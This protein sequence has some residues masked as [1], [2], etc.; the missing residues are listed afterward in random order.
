MTTLYKSSLEERMR[1]AAW[2]RAKYR[3]NP[4]YREREK[5]YAREYYRK[6]YSRK[7]IQ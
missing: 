7:S 5:A 3:N 1:K 6:H 4:E 2:K